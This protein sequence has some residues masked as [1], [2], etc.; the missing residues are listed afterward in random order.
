MSAGNKFFS[1]KAA[2]VLSRVSDNVP[3]WA[4]QQLQ[5]KTGEHAGG[6]HCSG[7]GCGCDGTCGDACKCRQK[8][9]DA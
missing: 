9:N 2:A 4:L 8:I 7:S 1:K 6:N 3:D 5:E